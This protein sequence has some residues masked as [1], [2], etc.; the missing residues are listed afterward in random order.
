MLYNE[1]DQ[2][3]IGEVLFAAKATDL[4]Y[5]SPFR[6][7]LG[8]LVHSPS[9]RR[10]SGK[11]QLYP[12]A[13]SDFF[14]N[15]L[16]HSLEVAQIAKSIALK[17]N[18]KEYYP[19]QEGK[20]RRKRINLDTDMVEFAGLAHDLGHPPFGHVGER[21]LHN[22]MLLY[23]GF[24]GNAQAFRILSRIEKKVRPQTSNL[25]DRL[26]LNL[27]A[28]TLAS[29]LKYDQE[30]TPSKIKEKYDKKLET[31][32]PV[33]GYYSSE[34]EIVDGI[35]KIVL[36]NR[37]YP[38]EFKTIEAN[39]MDFADDISYA[40]YDVE[41]AFKAEFLHPLKMIFAD[42][43]ILSRVS[44]KVG[45]AIEKPDF[46]PA[47]VQKT[48]IDIFEYREFETTFPSTNNIDPFDIKALLNIYVGPIFNYSKNLSENGFYRV[49]M[50]TG[51][52]D[53]FI[54]GIQFSYNDQFPAMSRVTLKADVKI[55][56]EVLKQI[57]YESQIASPRMQI[58]EYR[59]KEIIDKIFEVLDS[60]SGYNLLPDDFR[61]LYEQV[62]KKEPERKRV[63]CDFIAGMTD[64][65]AIE[66][67][68]RLTSEDPQTI[69][70]PF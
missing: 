30:I 55:Q 41:D 8:R 11:T 34:K 53:R 37:L 40:T 60:K 44:Q 64:R 5:R 51:F 13:E 26:G 67:Y 63:I 39:I 21:A 46:T 24:E 28:R 54:S 45:E 17:I 61:E 59:G 48:L 65:Y 38:H 25:S 14:R 52:V 47:L 35:K 18:S 42:D 29:I 31:F 49:P 2:I 1:S 22:L 7:D 23:G 56:V 66:F 58:A 15:R 68:G 62:K 36:R 50:T 16:T 19:I 4:D 20:L 3:R 10:L 32:K 9:F 6:R 43:Q 69:F 70:K 12:V 57:I 27:C 33:K